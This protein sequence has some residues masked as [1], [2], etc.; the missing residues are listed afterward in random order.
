MKIK[1]IS[2]KDLRGKNGTCPLFVRLTHERKVKY[3]GLGVSILPEHWNDAEQRI[4]DDCPDRKENQLIID[5]K[6]AELGK[7]IKRLEALDIEVNFDTLL[8]KNSRK[9]ENTVKLTT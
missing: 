8:N 2:R 4:T 3:V 1:V 9:L 7:Q 5:N 6:I